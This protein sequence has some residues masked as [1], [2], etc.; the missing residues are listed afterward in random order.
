M[1]LHPHPAIR[2]NSKSSFPTQG[3]QGL[4][5]NVSRNSD[6]SWSLKHF[7]HSPRE[8]LAEKPAPLRHQSKQ[9]HLFLRLK[10]WLEVVR[11]V[12]W[13]EFLLTTSENHY[14][15]WPTGPYCRICLIF[16]KT[17]RSYA[18]TQIS[19][20]HNGVWAAPYA[21]YWYST[22][23]ATNWEGLTD[24]NQSPKTVIVQHEHARTRIVFVRQYYVSQL[25]TRPQYCS[26][27]WKQNMLIYLHASEGQDRRETS[28]WSLLNCRPTAETP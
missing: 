14:R 24:P 7:P 1:S 27:R 23:S 11:R 17:Y 12:D 16:L 15:P 26:Q 3:L 6:G 10:G 9:D 2:H 19:Y 21:H 22:D 4:P 25:Q 18:S 8:M 20:G 28:S 13:P 5:H